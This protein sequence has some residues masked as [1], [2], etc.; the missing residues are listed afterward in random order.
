MQKTSMLKVCITPKFSHHSTGAVI[1]RYVSGTP[2]MLDGQE[3]GF[4]GKCKMDSPG[5]TSQGQ[6]SAA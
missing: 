3:H 2:G 6:D 4:R 1:D 5:M